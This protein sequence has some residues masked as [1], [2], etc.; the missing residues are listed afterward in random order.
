MKIRNLLL[1]SSVLT[2]AGFAAPAAVAQ[3]GAAS[4]N[5]D[6]ISVLGSRSQ[7]PRSAAD[8]PVPVDVISG[9]EFSTL[10]GSADLTDNLKAFIPSYTATPA[11]GDGSAFVRP[12]SLRGLAP[13]QTLV[14]VNGKRRHRSALIHFFSLAAGAG[15]HGPDV[16]M[17]PAIALKNVQVLRDGASSQYGADAIAG[18]INFEL[19]DADE[20][21]EAQFHVS[22]H[23]EGEVS[24]KFAGNIGFNVLGDGFVNLSAEYWDNPY[25][26]RG[27]QQGQAQQL[28]DA[29]VEGV[30]DDDPTGSGLA[31]TWGRTQTSGFRTAYNAGKTLDSGAELYAFG[32][33]AETLGDYRYFYRAAAV[34]GDPDSSAHTEVQQFIDIHGFNPFPAGLTPMLHGTQTDFSFVGGIEGITDNGLSYDFSGSLG[35]NKLIYETTGGLNAELPLTDSAG[36]WLPYGEEGTIQR[37]FYHGGYV[38]KEIGANADFAMPLGDNISLAFGGEWREESYEVI[39]GDINSTYLGG[40]TGFT[41]P[42]EADAAVYKRENLGVYADVEYDVT[43]QLFVQT[44]VRYEDFSDFGGTLNGKVAARFALTDDFAIR[45]AWSTGFHA[46]TPGQSNIQSQIT[47]FDGTTGEMII[48]GLVTPDSPSAVAVGGTALTEETSVNTSLGFTAALGP[49]DLTVD[50]YNIDVED[51]IY[52]TGNIDN[53]QGGTISFYTNALDIRSQGVDVVANGDFDWGGDKSTSVVLAMNYGE[54]SVTGQNLVNGIQPVSDALVEDIEN[55]YPKFRFTLTTNTQLTDALNLMVRGNY[56]GEHYDERGTINGGEGSKSWLIS[57]EL[58]IDVELGYDL[59]DSTR[60][61]LGANNIL[62]QYP[63]EIRADSGYANREFNGLLYGRRTV[64]NYE[65]GSVYLRL[66]QQF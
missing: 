55:N 23:Y 39:A 44:A 31:Q 62:D 21:G 13:D 9:D 61:V 34:P 5:T 66:S 58:F 54:L 46:P 2:V 27:I 38:Q 14:L 26:S 48:E 42:T 64:A 52:R 45:G 28:I 59:S 43:D 20:G 56:Y 1:A 33:Y 29:G 12:T 10:G 35:R 50:A 17:I 16:G 24:S 60:I 65:G 37:Y 53:G 3:D 7:K 15:A 18:V 51:R 6:V 11:T 25:L 40:A 49:V 63:D 19:K 8:A 32:N 22:R 41:S 47:T 30:G 36:N 57:P 4:L